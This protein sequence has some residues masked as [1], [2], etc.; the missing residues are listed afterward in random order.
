MVFIMQRTLTHICIWKIVFLREELGTFQVRKTTERFMYT[1]KTSTDFSTQ[2]TFKAQDMPQ[3]M[4][5]WIF[6]QHYTWKDLNTG[7][8]M[9]GVDEDMKLS[10]HALHDNSKTWADAG[11]LK[12]IW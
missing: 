1:C 8:S 2:N 4:T 7:K 3:N 11:P 10:K 6:T 9:P 12:N 5:S